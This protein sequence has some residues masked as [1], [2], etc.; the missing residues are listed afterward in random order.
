M[1]NTAF[2]IVTIL[3]LA[4]SLVAEYQ[5]GPHPRIFLTP[6]RVT[7]LAEQ[8]RQPGRAADDYALVKAE[9]DRLVSQKALRNLN[10]VWH[11][12][13][14]MFCAC[15]AYLVERELGN[16]SAAV[17]ARAVLEV[18]GDGLVLSNLGKGQFGNFALAYDWLYDAMTAEQRKRYGDYLSGWLTYYTVTPEIVLQ[19]GGWLYNK[20]W[21]PFH[22]GTQDAR[23]AITAKLFVALAI[24]G[25]GTVG[26][27]QSRRFLDSWERRIPADCIPV[28][29]MAGG[30]WPESMGHG[31]YGPTKTVP[32]AFEAW[33]TATGQDW[34]GLGAPNSFLKEMNR[35]A[36]YLTVPFTDLPAYIDDNTDPAV[37]PTEWEWTAPILGARY[38]DPV[39]NYISRRL[40]T[41][42]WY[43]VPWLRL[44][45]YDDSISSK[46]PGQAGWPTARL[47]GGAG[48]VY[49]R[50]RWDDPD[51]TWAFF[52][53]GPWYAD[54]SRDDEGHFLIAKKGWLV[55]RS[56]GAGHNDNDYYAGGSLAFNLVTVFD[57]A[58]QFRRTDPGAEA[59]A[60]GATRN[61]RD[62]GLIR[63]VYEGPP[64]QK[65]E[66]G[67]ITAYK[68]GSSYTYAAADLTDGYD[69]S[70]VAQITRQFLYLRRPAEF[71]VV[72][73]R[74][75]AVNPDLAKHWFLHVPSEPA[76][77]GAGSEVVAGHVYTSDNPGYL[78]WVSSP[79]GDDN[80][81]LTQGRSRAFLTSLLPRGS[82]LTRRGGEGH[83]YWGHPEE[84]SAQYNHTGS[85]SQRPP[86]APW[87]IEVQAAKGHRRDYFLHVFEI[88]DEAVLERSAVSLVEP[89]SQHAGVEIRTKDGGLAE[90]I[91]SL[92]GEMSARVKFGG[93]TGYEE[94]P[95]AVDTVVSLRGD[96]DRNGRLTV[97]DVLLLLLRGRANPADPALDYDG[98]G[99]SGLADA[100]ALLRDIRAYYAEA[101]L[102]GETDSQG[103][104]LSIKDF[105]ADR[106]PNNLR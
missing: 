92:E 22:L 91:F 25:A 2:L 6:A 71:F 30:A 79:A 20:T 75:E 58:E 42:Y 12:Q 84:P 31:S 26:E 67:H 85:Q 98:D 102:A 14:D 53:A 59:V 9:A 96:Y 21:G 66:R 35:W 33:R 103:W 19:Y 104:D 44:I 27:E 46:S 18:W 65:K 60:A 73:D 81:M 64:D 10:S 50:S 105:S 69:R 28:F 43:R 89:D 68:H 36:V 82:R 83:D 99:G 101:L 34:F 29:D 72:F 15:L 78:T 11:L 76:V 80:L 94:L 56:G 95:A 62:G 100:V 61:E 48:H 70:K 5:L 77:A 97:A 87:R 38:R 49:L 32:W 63:H 47:F 74:V 24:N 51:A 90:V 45:A 1:K 17:Y 41:D 57:P 16:D 8:V 88:T 106:E 40:D 54:H 13:T 93:E 7:R 23:D 86:V 37:L 55:L 4:K 39:A 3:L 52:G